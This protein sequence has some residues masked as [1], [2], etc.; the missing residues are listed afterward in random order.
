MSCKYIDTC[1]SCSEWCKGPVQDLGTCV[2]FLVR[3]GNYWKSE[4]FKHGEAAGELRQEFEILLDGL[5]KS[6]HT[7]RHQ[8]DSEADQET[9]VRL[10]VKL[11]TL[12]QQADRI[13]GILNR[14]PPVI[15]GPKVLS[16][17]QQAAM[18]HFERAE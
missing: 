5:R 8:M 4:A 6:I 16:E 3:T 11:M 18:E 13:D 15:P 10:H 17:W 9:K 12:R 7:V 2:P 1:P 14:K